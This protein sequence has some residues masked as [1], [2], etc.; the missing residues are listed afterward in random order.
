MKIRDAVG[1]EEF[2]SY[3]TDYDDKFKKN[4]DILS[5]IYNIK[6]TKKKHIYA[7]FAAAI[8]TKTS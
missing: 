2:E 5:K 7:P 4:I 3:L 1:E 6:S 8:R